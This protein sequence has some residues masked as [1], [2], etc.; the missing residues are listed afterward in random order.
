MEMKT[1]GMGQ[2]EKSVIMASQLI[3]FINL[4][5]AFKT[6]ENCVVS[7]GTIEVDFP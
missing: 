3:F 4:I 6:F 7:F 1:K 2:E 5:L